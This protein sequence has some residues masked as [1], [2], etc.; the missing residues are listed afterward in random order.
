M[1]IDTT[2]VTGRRELTFRAYEPILRD[3]EELVA[4]R[5]VKVLGNWQLGQALKHLALAIDA[6]LDGNPVQI[7]WY[8]RWAA[9]FLRSSII[10]GRLNPGLKLPGEAEERFVPPADTPPA[11]G[12]AALRASIARLGTT[13]E[14]KP[15]PILGDMTAEE[16]DNL[17][18]RHAELH[19]SFFVPKAMGP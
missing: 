5:E 11:D 3:A 17:H 14:R 10:Y 4:A 16:W 12:L 2:A 19:L 6:S 7:A 9:W 8:I 18:W 15:H 1:S 13:S